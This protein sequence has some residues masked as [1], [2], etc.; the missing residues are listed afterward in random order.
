MILDA[1]VS[2]GGDI[3]VPD[4]N[5]Q[6]PLHRATINSNVP[7]VKRLC[8]EETLQVNIGDNQ[9]RTALHYATNTKNFEIVN[10][11]LSIGADPNIQDVDNQTPIHVIAGEGTKT[12]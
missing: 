11:L 12:W 1:L 9:G 5:G 7:V 8:Q 6:T 3:N 10:I 2:T 4:S